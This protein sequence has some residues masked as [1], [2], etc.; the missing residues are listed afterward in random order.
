MNLEIG[1][2]SARETPASVMSEYVI[3]HAT[4]LMTMCG[5]ESISSQRYSSGFGTRLHV[6]IAPFANAPK[7]IVDQGVIMKDAIGEILAVAN[8]ARIVIKPSDDEM[9][10]IRES[11]RQAVETAN[12][13]NENSGHDTSV[14]TAE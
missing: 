7:E 10:G 1:K 9:N 5:I 2:A 3:E 4:A 8:V 6:S 13:R 11:W 12:L 14:R